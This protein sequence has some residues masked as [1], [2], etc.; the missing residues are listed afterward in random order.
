[1]IDIC[2]FCSQPARDF[3]RPDGGAKQKCIRCVVGDLEALQAEL[4]FTRWRMAQEIGLTAKDIGN[5][6][7]E[8]ASAELIINR[9]ELKTLSEKLDNQYTFSGP[10]KSHQTFRIVRAPEEPPLTAEEL[11]HLVWESWRKSEWEVVELEDDGLA[12]KIK[13]YTPRVNVGDK[14]NG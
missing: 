11:R 8:E 9:A 12:L 14:N 13:P 2:D 7:L 3:Y 6:T 10:V 5:L 4:E 1:M